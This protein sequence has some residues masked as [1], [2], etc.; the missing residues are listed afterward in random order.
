MPAVVKANDRVLHLHFSDVSVRVLG[1][2]VFLAI[3]VPAMHQIPANS[4]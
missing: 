1:T 3:S 2:C 4:S